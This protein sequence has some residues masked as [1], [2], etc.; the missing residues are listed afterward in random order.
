MQAFTKLV[1]KVGEPPA[2]KAAPAA[3]PPP[4][5]ALLRADEVTAV[6]SLAELGFSAAPTTI[7]KV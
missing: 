2:P 1:D 6:P 4:D 5:E 7:F 3:I